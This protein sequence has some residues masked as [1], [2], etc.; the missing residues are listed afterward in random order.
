MTRGSNSLFAQGEEFPSDACDMVAV[1]I[2]VPSIRLVFGRR[3]QQADVL[4]SIGSIQAT[5]FVNPDR[6]SIKTFVIVRAQAKQVARIVRPIV[7]S[8]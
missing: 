4:D 6:T 5:L 1:V 3:R 2:E 8:T 7:R